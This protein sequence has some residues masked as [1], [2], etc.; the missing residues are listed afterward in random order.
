MSPAEWIFRSAQIGFAWSRLIYGG[1]PG[2][3]TR[4]LELVSIQ[5]IRFVFFHLHHVL[6]LY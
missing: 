2:S 1:V 5:L 4:G 6:S 3:C